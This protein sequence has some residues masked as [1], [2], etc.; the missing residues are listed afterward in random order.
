[1][2][3]GFARPQSQNKRKML[4]LDVQPSSSQSLRNLLLATRTLDGAQVDYIQVDQPD[5]IK[6]RYKIKQH[7]RH[8]VTAYHLVKY[9]HI[10]ITPDAINFYQEINERI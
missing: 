3:K 4:I 10:C 2:L 6:N 7:Q 8:P 1:M 5:L 9:H